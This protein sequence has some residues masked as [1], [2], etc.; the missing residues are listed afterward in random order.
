MKRFAFLILAVSLLSHPLASHAQQY[1]R[2]IGVYPGD[3][4]EYTGPS[5]VSGGSTY[6]NLALNRPAYQSSAY[7]Y[8]LTAQLVTD[9]IVE[10]A[11]PHWIVTS[12]S[13]A[14]ILP[15][16][17]R[18]F[19][20]DGGIVSSVDV[21]GDHPWVEFDLEGGD[22]PPTIDRIDLYLRKIYV[23]NLSSPWT[24]TVLGSNDGQ[25][26][27][28]VGL[29]T[30]TQW[31]SMGFSGPSFEQTIAFS[32][33]ASFRA[34]RLQLSAAAVH[35]WE[36]AELM[37]FH[38]D[39]EVRVAGPTHFHSVWMS[40]GSGEEWVYVDLGAVSTFNR[41]SLAWIR[42][43]A[44]GSL[45]VS[46]DATHWQI[47][48]PLPSGSGLQQDISLAHPAKG[49]YVRV[50]MTKPSQPGSQYILSELQ[51]FGRGGLVPEP[52]PAAA[53]Q[54]NGT[55]PLAGGAWRLQ[56][57]SLVPADGAAIS[58]PG[59]AAK[60]WRIA[61]VPGTV[62][63]SYLN[64]GAI[65]NP[66][67]GDNQ[68]A[69]SDSFFCADFW[70]RNEFLAP[71]ARP[72]QQHYWLNFDG[73]N[74]KA[75][76]YLNGH[77]LGRIDGGFTRG[78]FDV[79]AL[80]HPGAL[81]AVAV[82]ILANAN[83]GSTK[84]KA[85][86][87]LNGGALGR[88]NPTYHASIGWDWISTIRG[89]DTG[90]WSNVSLTTSGSVTLQDPLVTTTLPLPDITHADVTLAATLAN[91]S[92][93]P[94]SGVLQAHFGSVSVETPVTLAPSATQTVQF[95]PAT[96]PN[97]HLTNPKLWWP[98]GY[99]DPNLY[100]VSFTFL[101]HGAVSD[102]TSFQA[103]IR[104]FTYSED[105]D[106]LKMWING[107]RF[108]ARG[109]NWGFPESMLRYRAREYETAMR[110]HRDEHFDMVRD[111]VGQTGDE[112]FYDAADRN[113]IVIWQDFW[114]ANP[115]DGPN[116]DD[117]ALF[118]ANAKD[119]LLRIR[120]H[121]SLGLFC[122]RNEGFPPP[123][124]DAG[125]RQLV[126]TLTPGS[127]YISSSADGPVSGHGPYRVEPLPYYFQHAPEKFHSE[128]GSPNIPELDTLRR[129]MPESALWPQGSQWPLHDFYPKNPFATA[130]DKQY[131]GASN[132]Q[133]WD[134]LAQFVDYNAYRGMFEGQNK[135]RLGLLIWMSHP[136][137]PSLLWQT[138][139]YFFDT[140][141]GYYGA[142]KGAEPLH[143]QW[144][145]ATDAIEVV[146]DSAGNQS[147]LTAHAEVLNIDG[148]LKWDK[149][150]TLD[151]HEDSTVSPFQMQFPAGLS[152][153]H[154][155][156]LTLSKGKQIL[157]S[158]FYLRGLTQGDYAGIRS[159][160]P[161][162]IKI[163]TRSH[164]HGDIWQFTTELRNVSSA[165]ALMVRIR[166]VRKQAGDPILPALFS[167]NYIALM[168]GQR[169]IIHAQCNVADTRGQQPQVIVEG[170]NLASEK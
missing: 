37:L 17:Q 118:L 66:D 93:S 98:V 127:H 138:Y 90:I 48:E 149:S 52:K 95:S 31:P 160:P 20:L 27:Q 11:L 144:N 33:P 145:A 16:Q 24:Y 64:D 28:Q 25:H 65:P 21:S 136:A 22:P 10:S 122:G 85:G 32:A 9:G 7:D 115:W 72:A 40:A 113:G 88:D 57:A 60:D 68:Y 63:T 166:L 51:V 164:R 54:P 121:A 105:G 29:A 36:V 34:Y 108:I 167:D 169:H 81:N 163:K 84:D 101:V 110:Y 18:E 26:W 155:I 56:R 74:W 8:N 13:S 30:G 53:P 15:K 46:D 5:L 170:Y 147:G 82:R 35:T 139:D 111:W 78:R 104:Q 150:S 107:R 133:Q 109:G 154:F 14:G 19:F 140:D 97:L 151:S 12:T 137:W 89:R 161:A 76:V 75:E 124:I 94:V 55:L 49:R 77:S 120:N 131:G 70:Y 1:T 91:H 38:G 162:K 41:V 116:P 96:Q 62:L 44:E 158:N 146:N 50:L 119:Y 99:G 102:A 143:I 103:G 43:A 67:F 114:L 148:S 86:P 69:I 134:S 4:A 73:I 61:T 45:Q 165:P 23:P 126:A 80:I 6:R 58:T 125:L 112:A 132:I 128:M 141:A 39:K 152:R 135:N 92:A 87:T 142:K 79:T 130:I 47:L 123:P 3:P 106:I 83:P 157:S 42:P 153:T 71:A 2:G 117:N 159:L 59:F 168:P 100:P 129:T 156:R